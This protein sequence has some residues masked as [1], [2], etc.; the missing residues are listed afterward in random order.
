MR[1][2]H[3]T[4]LLSLLAACQSS[5]PG[6]GASGVAR[7]RDQQRAHGEIL[8]QMHCAVC[9]GST[10]RGDGEASGFLFPPARDFGKGRFRLVSSKNGAP[11]DRD[12]V[13]TL[14]RGI[15][16]SAMPAWS[17][18]AEEDLESIASHVRFLAEQGLALDLEEA[19]MRAGEELPPEE[20]GRIALAR[21]APDQEQDEPLP[22]PADADAL[23][24]GKALF[25]QHCADCH[26]PDGRGQE[27][28][29]F[30]EDGTLN[31]ARNLMAGFLKGGRSTFELACRIRTGLPGSAMPPTE[32]AAQ[33][34]AALLAYLHEL[35]PAG[36]SKH[37]L[38]RRS[39]LHARRVAEVPVQP[40][41]SAWSAAGEIDVVLAPLWWH[42]E[43]VLAVRVTA[44]HD[45]EDL[46][47]R[48]SWPDR[49]GVV[50]LFTD[51][52]PTD[53]A[54]LQFSAAQEPALF[55]M[56]APGEPT[57]LW[58]WQALRL[59]DVAGAEDL[60]VPV[61]HLGLPD[62]PNDVRADVPR[63]QRLL[64]QLSPSERV[65]RITVEGV[66]TIR[67]ASR[68]PGEAHASASWED[69]TWSV[70]FVRQLHCQSPDQ[71]SLP[72]GASVQLACAVWNGAAGE[73]GARKSISIWQELALDP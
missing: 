20:A 67:S 54:A 16:G 35:I 57:N 49:T 4:W 12:L 73:R 55:G 15:P 32:L 24:R 3:F 11:S 47:V 5:G 40:G 60:L 28:P 34:E 71:I 68:I 23:K 46:A 10:G 70:V 61:P 42:A 9:H 72:P 44:L 36:A 26:G 66:Q 53:G 22:L 27:E 1:T 19:A 31:W 41:D 21:L 59:E 62:W 37:L 69:G 17:W 8:Y 65:D 64:T 25:N 43:A 48:L 33:D 63:Y 29:R 14:R 45:G 50:R 38:H 18:I 2:R 52:A 51:S 58:H 6:E 13:A 39:T 7:S 30:D 56:G